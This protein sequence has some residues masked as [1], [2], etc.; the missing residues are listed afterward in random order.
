LE[1]ALIRNPILKVL[2]TFRK[3]GVKSLLIGGQACIIYGAAEFSRDSDFAVLCD[4]ENIKRLKKA[5]RSLKAKNIYV[6]PLEQSYLKTG[7]A[8][9]FRCSGRPVKNFRVDVISKLRGCGS[10]EEL[11]DRRFILRVGKNISVDII[12]IEDLARSKKTQRDKDWLMLNRLVLSDMSRTKRPSEEKNKWWLLE[13][14]DSKVLINLSGSNKAL[15]KECLVERP[16]LKAALTGHA[17]KLDAQLRQ[18][19]KKER[20]DDR[21]YWKPLLKELEV[22]RHN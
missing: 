19:E 20:E 11:W 13:C 14:R 5:L 12:S 4:A 6:P 1:V 15:A 8:C 3:F 7:H 21:K 17:A 9:H 16:L 22:L 10:F 18:E 2:F